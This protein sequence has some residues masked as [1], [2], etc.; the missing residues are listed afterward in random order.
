LTNADAFVVIAIC[1]HVCKRAAYAA[2]LP[3][4]PPYLRFPQSDT[5][6]CRRE[7]KHNTKI[8]IYPHE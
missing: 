8:F 1:E 7:T 5:A 6:I 4:V 3:S 2:H